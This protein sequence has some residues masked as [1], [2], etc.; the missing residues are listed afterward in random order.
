MRIWISLLTLLF[1][2]ALQSCRKDRKLSRFI[3]EYD[4]TIR[5]YGGQEINSDGTWAHWDSTYTADGRLEYR[6]PQYDSLDK[7]KIN[8]PERHSPYSILTLSVDDIVWISFPVLVDGIIP[9]FS[10]YQ[11]WG[12]IPS[13]NIYSHEGYLINDSLSIYHYFSNQGFHNRNYSIKG[14]KK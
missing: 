10:T 5:A 14:I 12:A 8:L 1:V 11:N 13:G 7:L 3:G 9:S 4:L 2:L 6:T